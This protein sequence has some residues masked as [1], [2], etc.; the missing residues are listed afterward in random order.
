[1]CWFCRRGASLPAF[2]AMPACISLDERAIDEKTEMSRK[3]A[4]HRGARGGRRHRGDSAGAQLRGRGSGRIRNS[5]Q[6]DTWDEN[7]RVTQPS[8]I[9]H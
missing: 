1:M 2:V 7:A 3:H 6:E 5:Y 8:R 4:P 9:F